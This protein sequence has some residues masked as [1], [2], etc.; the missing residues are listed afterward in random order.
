MQKTLLIQKNVHQFVLTLTKNK[1]RYT[2]QLLLHL[3]QS[4]SFVCYYLYDALE[5]DKKI[6]Q[7]AAQEVARTLTKN[8]SWYLNLYYF[9]ISP[10]LRSLSFYSELRVI[11]KTRFIFKCSAESLC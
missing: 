7:Y 2:A 11:S 9:V 5:R 6:E 3:T 4:I 1:G 10:L 8:Q